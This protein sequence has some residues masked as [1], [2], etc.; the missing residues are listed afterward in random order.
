MLYWIFLCWCKILCFFQV[1]IDE[2]SLAN[3]S[4]RLISDSKLVGDHA[5]QADEVDSLSS[6][7]GLNTGN[8][9]EGCSTATKNL[10]DLIGSAP[11]S[12]GFNSQNGEHSIQRKAADRQIVCGLVYMTTQST[13]AEHDKHSFTG[14][15]G[16]CL[17]R[18]RYFSIFQYG[19]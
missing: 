16:V 19:L 11:T 8:L 18:K 10:P 9:P 15:C 3:E 6:S 1:A 12:G 2:V 7:E 13:L 17:K 14:S 4:P 5:A